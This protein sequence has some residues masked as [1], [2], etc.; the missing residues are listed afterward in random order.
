[1]NKSIRRVLGTICVILGLG[2][3]IYGWYANSNY[4]QET[5]TFS[6]YAVLSSS[7]DRYKLEFINNDGR[8]IDY[9]N[10]SL[11]T[12]E[13][14]SYAMLRAV[15]IDDKPTFDLVWKFTK[16]N[17][18]NYQ[19]NLFG[20][21]WGKNA[22]GKY[23]FITNG[24]NN[25]ATDADEDIALALILAGRRW[26]NSTYTTQA[27][28]MLPYLY[29]EDTD[30]I[31]GKRYL[32]PGGWAKRTDN[33]T[34]NVSYF[35]PASWRIF[36]QIDHDKNDDWNSLL[37][38]SYDLL[39]KVGTLTINGDK[40]DGLPPDW[41]VMSRDGTFQAPYDT[42]LTDNNSFDAMRVPW[43]IA[44]DYQWNKD[45]RDLQ[46]LQTAFAEYESNYNATGRLATTYA[47]NGVATDDTENPTR[48]ATALGYFIVADPKQ[49]DSIYQ[50]KIIKLYSNANNTFNSHLPY[51][52]QNWLWFG[53]ALYQN[54]LIPYNPAKNGKQN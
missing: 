25:T 53:T 1:M 39:N 5:R 8:V 18:M 9:S 45:P 10:H 50:N 22:N 31:Q 24:G 29:K 51:Y 27:Q 54:F 28:V 41:I 12:S 11:T 21:Q 23:G 2:V 47:Y 19:T 7:W 34:L 32:L 38:P 17:M 33:D 36:A 16:G 26:N 43:E 40:G 3:A 35:R 4:S 15:W 14:Q 44:L 30:V 42:G 20:W 52:D 48:Y 37:T 13:G 46:Y 6:T 49:A